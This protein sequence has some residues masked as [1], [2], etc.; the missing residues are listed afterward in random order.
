VPRPL[1]AYERRTRLEGPAFVALLLCA[2]LGVPLA[3][4]RRL[5]VG[6]LMLAASVVTLVGPIAVLYFDPRYAIPGYGSLATAA[7]IGAAALAERL[8]A[9]GRGRWASR[10][11]GDVADARK[12][13]AR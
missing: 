7:A 2:L 6:L 8:L 13:L 12:A 1:D 11:T 3:R 9:R 5:A 10:R 4:G